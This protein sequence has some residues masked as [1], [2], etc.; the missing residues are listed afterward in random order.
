MQPKV[1][2]AE[3]WAGRGVVGVGQRHPANENLDGWQEPDDA[4]MY[5]YC[6]C[7]QKMGPSMYL[8]FFNWKFF[9]FDLILTSFLSQTV[10]DTQPTNL[11]ATDF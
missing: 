1:W 5:E 8:L 2:A 11:E 7:W 9:S 3:A 4:S 10:H 6:M